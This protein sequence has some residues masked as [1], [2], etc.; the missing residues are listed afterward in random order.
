MRKF[1]WK[2]QRKMELRK[3]LME[4]EDKLLLLIEMT[5]PR[6]AYTLEEWNALVLKKQ[7]MRRQ[8]ERINR[9]LS[10]DGI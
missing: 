2:N 1:R 7:K 8:L 9:E 6:W 10:A 5:L 4:L 3:E